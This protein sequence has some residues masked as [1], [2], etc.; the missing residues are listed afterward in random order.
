[1]GRIW[2]SQNRGFS[3]RR[4]L[5]PSFGLVLERVVFPRKSRSDVVHE[6][7]ANPQGKGAA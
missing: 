1:M 4:F 7:Q 3:R 5:L 2:I 6:R